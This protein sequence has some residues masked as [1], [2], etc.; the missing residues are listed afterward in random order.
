[1]SWKNNAI[2]MGQSDAQAPASSWRDRAI[3]LDQQPQQQMQQPQPRPEDAPGY[4]S[5]AA[6]GVGDRLSNM[7]GGV[8][9]GVGSVLQYGGQAV[10]A[11]FDAAG[12]PLPTND[13]LPFN[14]IAPSEALRQIGTGVSEADF[15]YKP[16]FTMDRVFEDP[17]LKNVAGA[18]GEMA[19][20]ALAD[21]LGMAVAMPAYALSRN[22]EMSE[23]RA[24]N[25]NRG[26]GAQPTFDEFMTTAPA[27]AAT[28]MLDKFILNRLLG[29][30]S[31]AIQSGKDVAKAAGYGTVREAGS[32]GIQEGVIEYAGESV[33]TEK[34]WDA[35]T[36]VKRGVGGMLVGG[37]VGGGVAGVSAGLRMTPAEIQSEA[38]RMG[39][40]PE[41]VV[42]LYDEGIGSL[43][44][45]DVIAQN[46]GTDIPAPATNPQ[47]RNKQRAATERDLSQALAGQTDVIRRNDIDGFDD[48]G[49]PIYQEGARPA[50]DP[51][52]RQAN[53][54]TLGALREA[55]RLAQEMG[56]TLPRDRLDLAARDILLGLDPRET[57][58]SYAPETGE[59]A[60]GVAGARRGRRDEAIAG[61]QREDGTQSQG[62]TQG[63]DYQAGGSERPQGRGEAV[64]LLDAKYDKSGK[65]VGGEQVFSEGET[66][67]GPNGRIS[68]RVKTGDGREMTVPMDRITQESTPANPRMEQDVEARSVDRGAG[69]GTETPGPRKKTDAIGSRQ[70]L[71]PVRDTDVQPEDV[72]PAPE[73]GPAPE[74]RPREGQTFRQDGQPD[75]RRGFNEVQRPPEPDGLGQAITGPARTSPEAE[76]EAQKRAEAQRDYEAFRKERDAA[77]A[78]AES[79]GEVTGEVTG[80]AERRRQ[81][82][83]IADQWEKEIG[84]AG[85]ASVVRAGL[86]T[87]GG[88]TEQTVAFQQKRLDEARSKKDGTAVSTKDDWTLESVVAQNDREKKDFQEAKALPE[89]SDVISEASDAANESVKFLNSQGY[90]MSRKEDMPAWLREI[91]NTTTGLAGTIARLSKQGVAVSRGYKRANPD[92]RDKTAQAAKRDAAAL[93]EAI[94]ARQAPA[95]QP[96]V[97]A[98]PADTTREDAKAERRAER[99]ADD[100]RAE[101]KR[102]DDAAKRDR[103][104]EMERQR[105]GKTT[106]TKGADLLPDID[107]AIE[108]A[109][110]K[111]KDSPSQQRVNDIAD[112]KENA[113]LKGTDARMDTPSIMS[114]RKNVGFVEF[115]T[116]TGRFKVRNT[117]AR[118]REFRS[119]MA[120]TDRNTNPARNYRKPEPIPSTATAIKDAIMEGDLAYAYEL[121][122]ASGAKM[123]FGT[124]AK[125]KVTAYPPGQDQKIGG[126]DTVVVQSKDGWAVIVPS[127]GLSLS[128]GAKTRA[129]AVKFARKAVADVGEVKFRETVKEKST[130]NKQAD[131]EAEF[132]SQN[133]LEG[134]NDSA[135]D[136]VDVYLEEDADGKG[137]GTFTTPVGQPLSGSRAGA[138]KVASNVSAKDYEGKLRP[139]AGRDSASEF[140][141]RGGSLS[142][143]GKDSEAVASEPEPVSAK[144]LFKRLK[145]LAKDPN[146]T[147]EKLIEI[148]R[149]AGIEAHLPV[150][151]ALDGNSRMA[152]LAIEIKS[153][154]GARGTYSRK[155]N[156]ADRTVTIDLSFLNQMINGKGDPLYDQYAPELLVSEVIVHELVHATTARAINFKLDRSVV[157]DAEAIRARITKWRKENMLTKYADLS[158]GTKTAINEVIGRVTELPTYGLTN[159]EFQAFLKTLPGMGKGRTLFDDF[160][161][162][163]RK[164][165]GM[166][167]SDD[168]LLSDVIEVSKKLIDV[169]QSVPNGD[170]RHLGNYLPSNLGKEG[171]TLTEDL[172]RIDPGEYIKRAAETAGGSGKEWKGFPATVSKMAQGVRDAAGGLRSS[173]RATKASVGRDL[174]RAVMASTDGSMRLLV[175]K[176]DSPTMKS[177]PDMFHATAGRGDG[178]TQTMDEAV[179]SRMAT[180][181]GEVDK[182]V[183][184]I[185][186]ANLKDADVIARVENPRLSRVGTLGEAANMLDKF[187][188][189][190]LKYMKE[191]GV[192]I[193]EVKN[194]YFPRE[195]ERGLVARKRGEFVTAAAKAYKQTARENGQAMSD[196]EARTRGEAYWENT[197]FGDSGTPGYEAPSGMGTDFTSSRVF[198]K[199]AAKNLEQF[200]VRDINAVLGGYTQRAVRRAEIARRFG[201][202]WT[203]WNELEEKMTKEDPDTQNVFGDLRDLVAASAGVQRGSTGSNWQHTL[204]A[205][206]TWTTLATLEKSAIASL[207]ELVLAPMRGATGNVVGDFTNVANNIG[208]HVWNTVRGMTGSGRSFSLKQAYEFTQDL[209]AIAG[210]GSNH[211]MAARF[212]GG[213]PVGQIQSQAMSAF[214]R[215]NL[216][217]QLTNYTRVTTLKNGQVFLRRLAKD[218][219]GSDSRK[220]ALFLRE[221]GVPAGKE[222][223]FGKFV[224]EFGDNYPTFEQ[225]SRAGEVGKYY[226]TAVLR[227]TDQTVM[228]PS[229]STRPKWATSPLGAVVFQLQSF[230]YAFQKNVLNRY[231]R[232]GANTITGKDMGRLEAAAVT[233][234]MTATLGVLVALQAM[235]SE[236]RREV[237]D[238]NGRDR[239]KQAKLEEALS[240]AGLFG[241]ADPWMQSLSGV[242]YNRPV[243][244]SLVGPFL[245]GVGGATDDVIAALLRNSDSTNTAERNATKALYNWIMEPALQLALTPV[246]FSLLAVGATTYAIPRGEP[247][248]TDALNGERQTKRGTQPITGLFETGAG[249]AGADKY[250]GSKGKYGSSGSKYGGS[251]SKYK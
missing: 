41:E 153:G 113:K 137:Y 185:K 236:L 123:I 1:M 207:G 105:S 124:G 31:P 99:E 177:I 193:G 14:M 181:L 85:M 34:G 35:G 50:Q 78:E 159:P 26:P 101:Q 246:P 198:S 224:R 8:Y 108:K 10:E 54:E 173:G 18:V 68:L 142:R 190:E 76:A 168:S 49:D 88:P 174:F 170:V 95:A 71:N 112:A 216:L 74:P 156:E 121:A 9:R 92:Q 217:E 230:G 115:K 171:L 61:K 213:D 149:A 179:S 111:A 133:D 52:G 11:G 19:P 51:R 186:D 136:A 144:E 118:L 249:T 146:P 164:A 58:R 47:E 182:L 4:V 48:N 161:A 39:V 201:D 90:S 127:A 29:K 116:K 60:F 219:A 119:R 194:G 214:F 235:L 80:E 79:T 218:M 72:I 151:K 44:A 211:L 28:L 225:V 240:R 248:V 238:P 241:A 223:E 73:P 160:V 141:T 37:P 189:A 106:P 221:L 212:A 172:P 122:K 165:L 100:A 15:G 46:T 178:V 147:P 167:S 175:G 13:E 70:V 215:R 25:N 22:Q 30:G 125:G 209:G 180:R 227:F 55:E 3:P 59:Q 114:A 104:Y 63:R 67:P 17:S 38:E 65:L 203:K 5:N 96:K 197:I 23:A 126:V 82:E 152:D 109:E 75:E 130:D 129:D 250:G 107:A 2:P 162:M 139:F 135:L 157:D 32:E 62:F 148:A 110:A 191:A 77:K 98:V 243:L 188:K 66:V 56:I 220:N 176:F 21:M 232:L 128:Q 94:A 187:V 134:N 86:K 202:R 103:E 102:K 143:V 247:L 36:A 43:S 16:N 117:P 145:A 226:K 234:S 204:S 84:D 132:V 150:I 6:R 155:I 192:E 42:R 154:G 233:L 64:M 205:L 158:L 93:R 242:R 27:T 199:E 210:H 200:Y 33:G 7:V 244:T 239:T 40:S 20:A 91:A 229:N 195:L 237:Y 140:K 169:D 166:K 131:L 87:S 228:R 120:A 184:F 45:A 69:I 83:D 208:G 24:Q 163:V 222:A 81:I 196:S 251:D 138:K 245:G 231:A 53:P 57:V 89:I 206:R 12:M 97:E 183:A